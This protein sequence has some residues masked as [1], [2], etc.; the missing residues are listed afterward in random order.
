MILDIN[1]KGVKKTIKKTVLVGMMATT[2]GCSRP[3]TIDVSE[4]T[5]IEVETYS[6]KNVYSVKFDDNRVVDGNKYT[7]DDMN[8]ITEL[9]VCFMDGNDYSFIN[10]LPNLNKL[11]I[12]DTNFD[13]SLIK[14]VDFSRFNNLDIIIYTDDDFVD[15][16]EKRY[17]FLKDIKSINNLLLGNPTSTISVDSKFLESLKNVHNLSMGINEVT[18][19][20]Y[21]D[22]T[23]LNSLNL[24][25]FAYDI[26][27]YFTYDELENLKSVGVQVTVSEPEKLDNV[28]RSLKDTVEGMNIPKS[29]SDVEKL[30]RILEYV[31]GNCEY[32]SEVALYSSTYGNS[33][34]WTSNFYSSGAMTGVF[35]NSTQICG[36][37][38][39]YL[40][41]L[42]HNVGIESYY[43]SSDIHAWN[44][45]KIG[46]YYY[47]VDSTILDHNNSI[48]T[49]VDMNIDGDNIYYSPIYEEMSPENVFSTLN[50]GYINQLKG[51]LFDPT[52]GSSLTYDIKHVPAGVSLIDIPDME[53]VTNNSLFITDL[54]MN[55][56]KRYIK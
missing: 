53:E 20:D 37:Y 49:S 2:L 28:L 35:E 8:H 32:D 36:N 17:G 34:V 12:L 22:L 11:T 46:D 24:F 52:T 27:M 38:A 51:Y 39:A 4:P 56:T 7:L 21:T 15:F 16:N 6:F 23:H 31:V 50:Q 55:P 48:L 5:N 44:I 45:V 1:K 33:S 25:G 9:T 41:A 30:N 18:N 43:V 42:L 14:S 29:A 54:Y 26:A 13:P 47:Y 19:Y 3:D 40:N 10:N